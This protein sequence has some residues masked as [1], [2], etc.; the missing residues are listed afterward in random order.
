MRTVVF[1]T[2]DN[3]QSLD[4]TGPLEVLHTA[5][6]GWAEPDY[7]T[8]I[9]TPHGTPVRSESGL[10]IS[11]DASLTDLASPTGPAHIDTLAVVGGL[12]TRRLARDPQAL[13]D[14]RAL[15]TRADRVTSI[16]TG[17][18]V[19]AAAGLLDGYQATTHWGWCEQLANEHPGIE[20]LADRIYVQ[21]RDRWTSAGVT[22]G[23]DLFLALV[24]ADHGREIAHD[25]ARWLVVFVRR[26]GGQA[27]FSAQLA[28]QPAASPALDALLRWLPDHLT[29]DLTVA[30]LAQR[31]AMSPR[32]F[33]RAFRAE[34]GTTPA[35]YV[36]RVRVEAVRRLL[37]T[38]D[39]TVGAIAQATGF[40][41][42]ETLHRAFERRLGTTP[43]RYRLH[44]GAGAADPQE[45]E[46]GA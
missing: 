46:T 38:S 32:S 40:R 3:F 43:H 29:D 17:T 8:I 2:C 18:L 21:D 13:S 39:L 35:A 22:A 28:A 27:Q 33:A 4:L 31:A 23:I 45:T 19:L 9:A 12:G 25:V 1:V 5:T 30:A 26:P 36:E 7:Q 14:V 41:R 34:V 16:C 11:A 15:A 20:V 24:E 42:V 10:Q 6:R 44:F 37:E